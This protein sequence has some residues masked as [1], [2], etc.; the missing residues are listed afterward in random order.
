MSQ[1]TA[2][3]ARQSEVPSLACLFRLLASTQSQPPTNVN[4]N[5]AKYVV[6]RLSDSIFLHA[7]SITMPSHGSMFVCVCQFHL[8]Y[9]GKCNCIHR[10]ASILQASVAKCLITKWCLLCYSVS[11]LQIK[12]RV[13]HLSIT[14]ISL[15]LRGNEHAIVSPGLLS[16]LHCGF[17]EGLNGA[18]WTLTHISLYKTLTSLRLIPLDLTT[19][20]SLLLPPSSLYF[21]T[22]PQATYPHAQS[23]KYDIPDV[24]RAK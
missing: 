13:A 14:F 1:V 8:Q 11:N 4:H 16:C 23:F 10:K 9:S 2:G 6:L 5:R 7:L 19:H 12:S 22:D 15:N 18:T 21:S 17:N 24:N 3:R 20:T